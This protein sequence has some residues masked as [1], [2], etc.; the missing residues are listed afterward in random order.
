MIVY[1]VSVRAATLHALTWEQE[2]PQATARQKLAEFNS[3]AAIER[4]Q[5]EAM[6]S[7]GF[8]PKD[9]PTRLS[10]T[11]YANTIALA[12]GFQPDV[13]EVSAL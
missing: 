5:F 2:N 1:R 6:L 9:F 13:T 11:V 8:E 12:C 7:A 4:E 3:Y 10:A